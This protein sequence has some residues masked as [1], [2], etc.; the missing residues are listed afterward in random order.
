MQDTVKHWIIAW[1]L[2]GCVPAQ[3][4]PVGMAC[5]LTGKPELRA[6][7]A[8]TWMPLRLLQ[9]LE[10][11]DHVRCGAGAEA[12]LVLFGSGERFQVVAGAEGSVKTGKVE[13]AKSLGGL[14]GPSAEAAKTLVGART[15]AFVSRLSRAPLA[16]SRLTRN[17]TGWIAEG[18]RTFAWDS[19]PEAADYSFTL[20]DA[21]G[22]VLWN[23]RTAEAH[24]DYPSDSPALAPRRAYLWRLVPYGKSGLARDKDIRWG[25]VTTLTRVDGEKLQVEAV[26]LTALIKK[27][28]NDDTL[29]ALLAEKYRDY[30][31]LMRTLETLEDMRTAGQ[32]G[33]QEAWEETVGQAGWYARLLAGLPIPRNALAG[34]ETSAL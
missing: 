28:P 32:E 18:D 1:L 23:T 20:I 10:T 7:N 17:F 31:V 24:A 9:K 29:R 19:V 2:F 6:A 33:A 25:V 13:G 26:K 34:G 8:G 14:N 12:I 15:G 16:P 22:Y 3:A 27:S 30:G 11:G 21:N 5:R 4:A